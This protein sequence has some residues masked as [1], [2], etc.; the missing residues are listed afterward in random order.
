MEYVSYDCRCK[1]D[2]KKCKL[3][4]KWNIDKCWSERE[5]LIKHHILK[6]TSVSNPRICACEC[7]KKSKI[8]EYFM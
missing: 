4:Q 2:G 3:N 8:D 6:E 7:N 1:S 5:K